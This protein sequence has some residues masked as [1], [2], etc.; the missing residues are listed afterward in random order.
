[1]IIKATG[2]IS[3][4]AKHFNLP[5]VGLEI[6]VCGGGMGCAFL[7]AGFDKV[8]SIDS[9]K[10]LNQT[11]DGGYS[12]EWHA[13]NYNAAKQALAKYG[14]KSVIIRGKSEDVHDQIPDNSV[15]VIFIDADHRY[16]TVKKDIQ[17][18]YPKLIKGGIMSF[19]DYMNAGYGV[20]EAVQE[21]CKD[22]YEIFVTYDNPDG[23]AG[24]QGATSCYFIK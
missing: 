11:G 14:D 13:I 10:H 8:Y 5:L 19:H 21:F 18:Y 23:E 20:T 1:M 17:N 7:E 22:R 12:E 4:L 24:N 2:D 16:E 6:G 15:S 9:W 3:K